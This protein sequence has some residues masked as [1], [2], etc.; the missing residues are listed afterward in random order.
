MRWPHVEHHLLADVGVSGLTHCCLGCGHSG[1]RVGRFNFAHRKA[2]GIG[3][4]LR[5]RVEVRA[6]AQFLG[7]AQ[8]D[9]TWTGLELRDG[10]TPSPE[11]DARPQKFRSRWRMNAVSE[12]RMPTKIA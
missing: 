8:R 9:G 4:D 1:N 6:Q 7:H 12:A 11:C 5:W 2:H 3:F 10:E